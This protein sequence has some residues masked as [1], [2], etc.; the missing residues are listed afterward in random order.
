MT[1][2]AVDADSASLA[3]LRLKLQGVFPNADVAAF[4]NSLDALKYGT[5]HSF[6]VLFTDVRLR[7]IDGYL[8]IEALRA[9]QVF[10]AYIVSGT[11]EKPDSLDWMNVN[12]CFA[13]PITERELLSVAKVLEK[14]S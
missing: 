13:K 5:S 6:D 9:Q 10:S 4:Q 14:N 1:I 7:P 12:G 8:L 3:A 2:M 11:R